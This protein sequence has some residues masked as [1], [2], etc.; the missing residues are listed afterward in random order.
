MDIRVDT[1]F[2]QHPKTL[3]LLRRLGPA[4]VVGLLRLWLWAAENRPDGY[5]HGLNDE[6]VDLIAWPDQTGQIGQ[7]GQPADQIQISEYFCQV[8]KEL[9]W[10]DEIEGE[11]H[12]HEWAVHNPWAANAPK[13]SDKA[14][15]SKLAS[16]APAAYLALARQ[17][18]NSIGAEEYRAVVDKLQDN[19]NNRE[20]IEDLQ[21]G[22][23]NIQVC[24]E[25]AV[26]NVN[27]M[28]IVFRGFPGYHAE[29]ATKERAWV[30]S[31][32]KRF[33]ELDITDEIQ[34]AREWVK[35]QDFQ[36]KNSKA[37]ILRWLERVQKERRYRSSKGAGMGEATGFPGQKQ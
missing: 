5:L 25:P 1:K 31:L 18:R 32:R 6:D 15:F 11:L 27:K 3:K 16:V 29:E 17:G 26:N 22:E 30:E 33:P 20:D 24:E 13:R 35:L 28:L 12:L 9:R 14:R 21:E 19:Q 7:I 4:G 10:I 34:K 36:V 37:Y 23:D 8:A 2:F